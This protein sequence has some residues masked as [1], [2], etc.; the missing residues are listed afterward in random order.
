MQDGREKFLITMKCSGSEELV[1]FSGAFLS[2][3]LTGPANTLDDKKNPS[4]E[5]ISPNPPL[6][7]WK[8]SK[9]EL[10]ETVIARSVRAASGGHGFGHD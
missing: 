2:S 7:S 9:V 5:G 10:A 1:R 4:V 6:R 8:R 3:L